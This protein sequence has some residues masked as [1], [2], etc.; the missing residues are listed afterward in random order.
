MIG[1][2]KL[3][4]SVWISLGENPAGMDVIDCFLQDVDKAVCETSFSRTFAT[5]GKMEID[6]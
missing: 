3:V 6:R 2:L 4:L 1:Q 5:T